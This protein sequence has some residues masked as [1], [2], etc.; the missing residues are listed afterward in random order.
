MEMCFEQCIYVGVD[1]LR[2]RVDRRST[3]AHQEL[4]SPGTLSASSA[5]R[6]MEPL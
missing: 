1:H 5:W 2:W 4:H 3:P 6:L